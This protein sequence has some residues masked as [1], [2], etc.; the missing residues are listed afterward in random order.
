MRTAREW[1]LSRP[2]ADEFSMDELAQAVAD[3]EDRD[4]EVR[5]E[6]LETVGCFLALLVG[7]VGA[8]WLVLR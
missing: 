1:V 5:A 6:T 7:V 8:F 4:A 2:G 3:I